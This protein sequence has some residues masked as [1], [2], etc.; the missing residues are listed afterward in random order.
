[1]KAIP[2][3]PLA[4]AIL[5]LCA[6]CGATQGGQARLVDGEPEVQ[7]LADN[8][9]VPNHFLT[10]ALHRI[11]RTP[12][13]IVTYLSGAPNAL[14]LYDFSHDLGQLRTWNIHHPGARA[15]NYRRSGSSGEGTVI[16]RALSEPCFGNGSEASRVIRQIVIHR[17][18]GDSPQEALHQLIYQGRTTHFIIAPDGT[19]FQPLDPVHA[20][21]APT[22]SANWAIYIALMSPRRTHEWLGAIQRWGAA[23]GSTGAFTAR[24]GHHAAS[25]IAPP[26]DRF[27]QRT[28]CQ[29]HQRPVSTE[30]YTDDQLH[31]ARHLIR[32]LTIDYSRITLEIPIQADGSPLTEVLPRAEFHVGVMADY[33]TRAD[34]I[35]PGCLDM[36]RLIADP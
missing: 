18:P 5:S 1:M 2:T 33:H 36:T 17:A 8:L 3:L 4:L 9:E 20:A 19:V 21:V 22:P 7:H 16:G 10:C 23:L 30:V 11:A 24:L 27:A 34:S 29:R 15:F 12:Y 13:P 26:R 28:T 35:E 6:A 14:S 31:S 25:A 32:L